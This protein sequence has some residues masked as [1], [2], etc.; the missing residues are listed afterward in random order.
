MEIVTGIGCLKI[1]RGGDGSQE[2]IK[3]LRF[4]QEHTT[5][6]RLARARAL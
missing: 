3:I 1:Q 2:K 4:Y 5:E 6:P